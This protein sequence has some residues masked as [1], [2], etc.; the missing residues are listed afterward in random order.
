MNDKFS[1]DNS[2]TATAG[3]QREP[4]PHGQ[5]ALLLI[6][7]LIHELIARSVIN[8]ANAVEIVEVAVEIKVEVAA[9][10]DETLVTMTRSLA[11]L[12]A[13]QDSFTT[14]LQDGPGGS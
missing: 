11:L 12:R 13:I 5:A 4:D 7:S 9:D 8:V 2:S 14:G 10:A 3:R 1:N 6:E